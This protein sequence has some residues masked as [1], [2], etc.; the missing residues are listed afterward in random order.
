MVSA[1]ADRIAVMYAGRVVEEGANPGFF[2]NP[3]SPHTRLLVELAL[4]T[5]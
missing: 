5:V 4:K 3:R 2:E 1:V